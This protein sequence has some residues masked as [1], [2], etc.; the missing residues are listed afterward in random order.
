[1]Q[2]VILVVSAEL[3][4]FSPQNKEREEFIVI[5]VRVVA[6]F[7]FTDFVERSMMIRKCIAY[8]GHV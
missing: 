1:M 5:T 2:A 7:L 4:L 3:K 6:T 8:V